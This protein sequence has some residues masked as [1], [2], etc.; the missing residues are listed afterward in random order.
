MSPPWKIDNVCLDT[1]N[2]KEV[3]ARTMGILRAS[4]RED[5]AQAL[6]SICRT[7]VAPSTFATYEAAES[8]IIII[9]IN[10]YKN[11]RGNTVDN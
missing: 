2:K 3:I 8:A 1:G 10:N 6:L 11:E 9:I 5:L 7:A 4:E